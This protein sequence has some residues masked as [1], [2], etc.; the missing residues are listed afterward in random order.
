[1]TTPTQP[2]K[3]VY[4]QN[5]VFKRKEMTEGIQY[6]SDNSF[7]TFALPSDNDNDVLTKT[8][9]ELTWSEERAELTSI[10][11]TFFKG[12]DGQALIVGTQGTIPFFKTNTTFEGIDLP[13]SG[14]MFSQ[15]MALRLL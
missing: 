8:G 11:N 14:I 15:W 3:L 6:Y 7:D 10:D 4:L 2:E 13:S 1:M 9:D 5:G 12:S